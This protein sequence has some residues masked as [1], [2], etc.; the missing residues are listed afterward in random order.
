MWRT[1]VVSAALFAAVVVAAHQ[2]TAQILSKRPMTIVIPYTPGASSDTFQ[3]FVAK[4]VTDD[5]GQLIVVESRPGGSGTVGAMVVKQAPPDGYT[6]FQANSGTHAA[7]VTLYS[8]LPYDPIKDFTAITLMWSFPQLLVVPSNSGMKTPADLIALA[9]TKPGG[10]SFG[11]QGNGSTGHILGEMLRSV[12][13]TNMVHVP[14]RGAAAAS[15]DVSTGR[16]DFLFVSYASVLPFLQSGTARPI[17]NAGSSR[18]KILPVVP[19]MSEFG[20][21]GFDIGAWFGLVGPAGMPEPLVTKLHAA[22]AQAIRSPDLAK[23]FEDQ[24]AEAITD[25]PS[26]FAAFMASEVKRQGNLVKTL[27]IKAE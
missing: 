10:L 12:S 26:E 14:Y 11:S 8:S 3:R 4:K 24:G 5:T 20:F 21:K 6:L 17:A 22:F 25:T 27:G 19:L 2:G 7:N 13:G 15:L 23:Q 1:L 9:K 18:L 16:I